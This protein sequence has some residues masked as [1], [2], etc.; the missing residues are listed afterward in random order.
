MI[1]ELIWWLSEKFDVSQFIVQTIILL[2]AFIIT[3]IFTFDIFIFIL[4]FYLVLWLFAIGMAAMFVG[5][6]YFRKP[7]VQS[8]IDYDS[9]D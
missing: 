5:K 2:I 3:V 4:L 9:W 1:G 8:K 6:S 7:S